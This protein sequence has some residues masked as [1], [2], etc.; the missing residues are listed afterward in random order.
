MGVEKSDVAAAIRL[1]VLFATTT[2]IRGLHL[3]NMSGNTM[4]S[5]RNNKQQ[6]ESASRDVFGNT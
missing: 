6:C 2:S 5:F 4:K 3:A 1:G